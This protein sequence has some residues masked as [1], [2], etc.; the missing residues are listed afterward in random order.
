LKGQSFLRNGL[1][2]G[3]EAFQIQCRRLFDVALSLFECFPLGMTAGKRGDQGN[4][5][6]LRGVLGRRPNRITPG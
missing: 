2:V 1:S 5:A 3:Y 4:I 6:A